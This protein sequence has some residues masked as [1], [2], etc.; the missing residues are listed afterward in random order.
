MNTMTKQ[1]P[2]NTKKINSIINNPRLE[3]F[4]I[5]NARKEQ[6]RTT[7][8]SFLNQSINVYKSQNYKIINIIN[9]YERNQKLHAVASRH[10]VGKSMLF[11]RYTGRQPFFA[12][13][14]GEF[15]S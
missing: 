10:R 4:N 14:A 2:V 11:F 3:R 5:I 12:T 13:K 1:E 9:I 7:Q 8:C 6:L 15:Q